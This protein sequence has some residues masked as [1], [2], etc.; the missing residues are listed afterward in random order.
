MVLRRFTYATRRNCGEKLQA[1]QETAKKTSL[2]PPLP[3]DIIRFRPALLA[4][5]PP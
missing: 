2:T 4:H 1:N 3:R 5:A